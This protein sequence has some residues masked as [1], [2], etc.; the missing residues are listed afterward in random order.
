MIPRD[1][2]AALKTAIIDAALPHVPFEGFTG[3]VL[4]QAG[5]ETGADKETVA[6]LF[7]EGPLS[8]VEACSQFV[9]DELESL[10]KR[11]AEKLGYRL[12]DHRMELYGVSLARGR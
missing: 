3:K 11:I 9:D 8:L 12:V 2:D 10:Q 5:V 1:D 7:P 6:R 4:Q